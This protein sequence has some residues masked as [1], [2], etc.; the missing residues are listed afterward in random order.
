MYHLNNQDPQK[1][2]IAFFSDYF[3][4]S[5]ENLRKLVNNFSFPVRGEKKEIT[6]I[7]RFLDV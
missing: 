6:K 2:N 4:I 7:L 3:K 1:Y 5:T